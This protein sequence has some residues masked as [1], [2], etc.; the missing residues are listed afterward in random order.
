MDKFYFCGLFMILL[1]TT[2][3]ALFYKSKVIECLK[4]DHPDVYSKLGMLDQLDGNQIKKE[5]DFQKFVSNN[6][7]LRLGNDTLNALIGKYK[8]YGRLFICSIIFFIGGAIYLH[9]LGYIS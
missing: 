6:S 8:F 2:A 4:R 5:N 7:H 9:N 3:L 1:T